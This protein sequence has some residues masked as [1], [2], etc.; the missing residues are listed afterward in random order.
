MDFPEIAITG[1]EHGFLV[2]GGKTMFLKLQTTCCRAATLNIKTS[3]YGKFQPH[4][5]N[6]RNTEHNNNEALSH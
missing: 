3:A 5:T 4:M 6:F 2:S 1:I